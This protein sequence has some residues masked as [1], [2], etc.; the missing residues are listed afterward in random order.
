[1]TGPA[2]KERLSLYACVGHAQH[3]I[4]QYLDTPDLQALSLVSKGTT[5]D[6]R[7]RL[8]AHIAWTWTETTT[9]PIAAFVRT[10]LRRPDLAAHVQSVTLGGDM[11][12]GYPARHRV[13]RVPTDDLDLVEAHNAIDDLAVPFAQVWKARVAQGTMDAFLALMVSQL[14]HLKRLI[15]KTAFTRSTS[16]LGDFIMFTTAHHA[17]SSSPRF[18]HLKEL[19]CMLYWDFIGTGSFCQGENTDNLLPFFYLPHLETLTVDL[20]N[21]DTIRWPGS[22]PRLTNLTSL[23][24]SEVRERHLPE[25]LICLPSLQKLHY[26]WSYHPD[27]RSRHYTNR[28][29]LSAL[30]ASFNHVSKTLTDICLTAACHLGG[31]D[32]TL[33]ELDISGSFAGLR[34]LT[35]LKK[36]EIPIAFLLGFQP[37]TSN[38]IADILPENLEQLTIR[39]DLYEPIVNEFRHEVW[40]SKWDDDAMFEAIVLWIEDVGRTQPLLG[41][42]HLKI[43][44]MQEGE[45]LPAMQERLVQ[46]G[47]Q[48]GVAISVRRGWDH[49]DEDD[50]E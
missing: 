2:R 31:D 39:D 10:I 47:R 16:I 49:Q 42:L 33:P 28:L 4:L 40:L 36:L 11:T 41:R 27:L 30:A 43:D 18:G 9:P 24:L 23:S 5:F 15:M 32:Y 46:L 29:D 3:S 17:D 38:R 44:E 45:W 12:P 21:P 8:Y 34:D 25:I 14:N 22:R 6:V 19:S 35:R 1:M 48:N 13:L 20:D 37:S 50:I 7:H 26:D